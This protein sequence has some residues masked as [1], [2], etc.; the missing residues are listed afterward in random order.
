MAGTII[1]MTFETVRLADKVLVVLESMKSDEM[2]ELSDAVVLVKDG[3]GRLQIDETREF[4]AEKG[5]LTGGVAGL[6]VGTLL[7]GPIGGVLLGAAGGALAG[8]VI[9]L[10]IPDEKIRQVGQ[11]MDTAT[12]A[13]LIEIKSGDPQKLVNAMEESGGELFELSLSEEAQEQLK[14]QAADS[15]GS[16]TSEDDLGI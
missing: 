3:E 7:G 9:D 4:T 15:A 8:R 12:S 6:V 5:A 16:A 14:Q 2:F 11:A 13:I 1:V 10:G